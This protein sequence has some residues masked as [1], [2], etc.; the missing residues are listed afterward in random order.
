MGD[1]SESDAFDG[2]ERFSEWLRE[3][4]DSAWEEATRHRFV[5]EM[6][7]DAIDDAVFQR[8]LVQDYAFPELGAR[9]TALAVSQA[10]SMEEM[11]RLSQQLSV[12]TGGE[13]DYFQRAFEELGVPEEEW[14]DPNLHE[15]TVSFIDF[16]LRAAH[17]GNYE[18]TLTTTLAAEWVY[19]DW[20]T[21]IEDRGP[22]RW[23]LDEW[24]EIHAIPEFEE[25][26]EWLR[27]QL[28][29]YGPELSPRR[30][31]RVAD[32]F[33][34]TVDLEVDFFD[35]AYTVGQNG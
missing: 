26:V 6:G 5:E 20:A 21:H 18:E 13:N 2:G 19:L 16:M 8:Y 34:R 12:L 33:C 32:L 7:D 30:Q 28:D 11:E 27:D 25:Y 15:T 31:T 22:E 35:M 10:P 3:Q 9:R 1:M 29:T 14:H 23:Y 24:I 17:E 4:S